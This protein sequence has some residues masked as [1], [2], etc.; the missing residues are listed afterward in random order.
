MTI[1]PSLRSGPFFVTA[2]QRVALARERYFEN[3]DRPTGLVSEAVLQSWSRCLI[4]RRNPGERVAFDP[5]SASRAHH[6]VSKNRTLLESARPV[7]RE[8]QSAIQ[9]SG[10][11]FILT[12]AQG[13]VI[14]A[15][16]TSRSDGAVTRLVTRL[17]VNLGE[18]EIGTSAPGI[19]VKTGSS[20]AVSG[21]EH[22]FQN[23]QSMYCAA[24]P[25]REASGNLA[26]VLDISIEQTELPFDVPALVGMYST[27][28]E[29]RLMIASS[30]SAM[31]LRMQ[32][33]PALFGTPMEALVALNDDGR[34]AWMNQA[35][36]RLLIAAEMRDLAS[37]NISD[38][39]GQ[40]FE[41]FLE[42]ASKGTA[43]IYLAGN[44]LGVWVLAQLMSSNGLA[45]TAVSLGKPVV[46]PSEEDHSSKSDA[47]SLKEVSRH[48]IEKVLA[49]NR[50]NLSRTALALGVSRG[51]LY[52][53]LGTTKA[54]LKA[55]NSK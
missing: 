40:S 8:L 42:A 15:S 39:L 34:V 28:I 12:D 11:R 14:E 6:A 47:G 41:H 10:C 38:L 27:G 26:A 18:T 23:V 48:I 24:A 52:R 45:G 43:R 44:G 29:N 7:L 22:F 4:A 37:W 32:V 21:A 30:R 9:G 31:L 50:G 19:V 51:T 25:I 20:C 46:S 3:G 55:K 35:A 17:G 5:V 33:N 36:G 1:R 13:V 16:P 53:R 54:Q 2:Q 49:A